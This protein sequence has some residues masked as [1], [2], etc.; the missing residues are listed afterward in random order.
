[1]PKKKKKVIKFIG[2]YHS[3][4]CWG[5]IQHIVIG[6]SIPY[7][8]R[9]MHY[10]KQTGL[11]VLSDNTAFPVYTCP[12]KRCGHSDSDTDG[13][14]ADK[15]VCCSG[16]IPESKTS[17]CPYEIW[18]SIPNCET[19]QLWQCGWDKPS[20]CPTADGLHKNKFPQ[21]FI[22]FFFFKPVFTQQRHKIQQIIIFS[23][24]D[25]NSS[26][27]AEKLLFLKICCR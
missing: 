12:Q 4:I 3:E 18:H 9:Y 10:V 22:I 11:K 14:I 16:F 13:M 8:N 21:L 19:D 25:H 5:L 23:N 20:L 27:S 1:M 17:M 26:L 6:V 2:L 7:V 24:V 15:V